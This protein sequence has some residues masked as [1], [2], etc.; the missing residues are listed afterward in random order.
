MKLVRR[1]I[2]AFSAVLLAASTATVVSVATAPPAA[3]ADQPRPGHT[4]LVPSVPRNNTPR[5]SG[6]EIWDMEI[7]GNRVFIVGGFTSLTNTAS[8]NTTTVNQALLA[9][10]NINTGLIDTTFRPTFGGGGVNAVE[11]SPDGTKLYVGGTFNTVNGV[12][13]R[14]LASLNL[15]TG[16]PIAGFTAQG[17]GQVNAIAASDTTVYAGGRFTKINGTTRVGLAAVNGSTGAVDLGFDNQL[18]GGIGVNGTLTVQQLKLTH[19]NSKLLVVHT[20]RKIDGQD[21]YG[22]GLIDTASKQLLPWRSRIWE[23]NLQFVGGIQRIYSGDIAPDD[24]F[25]VVGSGSGGDRPPIND[26]AIA[27]RLTGGDNQQPLWISRCF[28]SVYSVAITERAVYI[29]GHFQFNESPTASDPWPG[30]DNVGYGT[31][32]G[33][34]GYGLGDEVVRRDHLGALDPATGKALEW[35]PGSNSFEGNKAMEATSRGLFVGGDGMM[36]GGIRTGRVAFY[37]FN[38]VTTSANDTTITSPIEGRVIP[39]GQQFTIQGTALAPSGVRRVQVEVVNGGGRYLQDDLTTWGASNTINATLGA[40]SG[41]TRAWS[42]TLTIPTTQKLTLRAKTFATNGTNDPTKAVKKIETFVFSDLAPDTSITSPSGSLLT[43]TTFIASGTARDD[44]GVNAISL[45]LRDANDNYVTAD[46]QL[47]SEYTTFRIEPDVVGAT[48]ATWRYEVNLPHEGAWRMGAMAIDTAGQSDLRWANRDWTVDT[49]GAP[50]TVTITQPISVIPPTTSPALTMTP[51]AP[52]TFRGTAADDQGL[53]SV[54]ISLRNSVT[55]ENLASDG[56]WGTGVQAGSYRVSPAGMNQTSYNWSYTTPFN[57]SPGIYSFSVRATDHQDLTTSST[58][59]GSLTINVAVPGD[60][61]PNGLLNFTGT[62]QSIEVLHL[63]LAGT[64][65]DD[66][67]VGSVKVALQDSET[68]KYVQPDG[69]L[70]AGFATLNATLASPGA[71]STTWTL[72]VNLPAAGNYG[73][74]AYAVDSS[75]QWD[76]STTG[77]TAR[78]LVFP[79]D[80]D[81]TL[82]ETLRSPQSGTTFGESRIVVSGRAEDDVAMARVEVAIV[83]GSAQYMSSNGSFSSTERWITTFLNSPGSPGSNYSYTTPAIPAGSYTVKVR[84]VDKHG[85]YPVS[86]DSTVTVA[87]PA[88]NL[89]PVAS[90]TTSCVQNSC[91][92][93]AR[94]T[95]DED[96]ATVTY[97]WSFGNGTTGTGSLPTRIYSTAGTF[98][99]TVTATDEYGATSTA[100]GTVTI[101]EPPTNVAPTAVFPPPTCVL[102][103]CNVSGAGST[104]PNVGDSLVYSF[105]W[106]DGTPVGTTA[107]GSHTYAAA[108]TYTITMTVSDG[109]GRAAAPV[110]RTVTVAP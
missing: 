12:S 59:R 14:K 16:A 97:A 109:W 22:V 41:S 37:D 102:L 65:T 66:L 91:T 45:Y 104:D 10:Y 21:R 108:G 33:L 88:G 84:P 44:F 60:V 8:G 5:I 36:Q 49:S 72:P 15:T 18:S 93:D 19:D 101:S 68:S 103:V 7:V 87:A 89:P 79:G 105:N 110:T 25:F 50:P 73:V 1:S 46:G 40:T 77:A 95:T 63:D 32:Q 23:D 53:A 2:T 69:T 54:E 48:A 3:A 30:L 55:R 13:K 106:G 58:F 26:T 35:N 52:L 94:G 92:F 11:A 20:A 90:F 76:T 31:G 107:S 42:L 82:V 70:A 64:A 61:A 81:P 47:T 56:T 27:F 4:S 38:T 78:Y 80:A 67:G 57:L 100:S 74:T 83:N 85:Q 6:G 96:A 28:D 34:S 51:G 17:N 29:G 39:G 71:T 9:A 62:D 24:S 75:G 43:S 86:T 98:T 99:V